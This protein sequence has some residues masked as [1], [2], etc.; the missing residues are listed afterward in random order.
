MMGKWIPLSESWPEEGLHVLVV[1]HLGIK[2]VIC[3][4][5]M[6]TEYEGESIGR[7]MPQLYKTFSKKVTSLLGL[8]TWG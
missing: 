8:G 2:P 1:V 7:Y 4:A 3:E 5:H 6:V